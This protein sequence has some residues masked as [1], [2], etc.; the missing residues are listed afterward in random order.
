LLAWSGAAAQ[1]LSEA[2]A[3]MAGLARS[4][5]SVELPGPTGERNVYTLAPRP[6][7]LCLAERD[8]DRLV[9]L[10]AVLAVGSRAVWPTEAG[11]LLQR[12]PTEVRGQVALAR[13]WS[14]P[15]VSYDAVLLHGSTQELAQVQQL[16]SRR[17]GPVVSVERMEPGE[18]A[19]PLERL[20]IER[21]LSINTAAAGGN[22]SLMTIS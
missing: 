21:A 17:D 18:T 10:A 11:A 9:Q 13:D 22:A 1:P 7:V 3:R 14:A 12:L 19:V 6:S 20:I 16:L 4:G 15:G 2:G 5:S 8:T